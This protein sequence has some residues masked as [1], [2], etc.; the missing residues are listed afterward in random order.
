MIEKPGCKDARVRRQHGEYCDAD[1]HLT[2][3]LLLH[4]FAA[5]AI[6][7]QQNRGEFADGCI[8]AELKI[9]RQCPLI[10]DASAGY[11][12]RMDTT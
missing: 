7:G 3:L 12:C 6:A 5:P 4:R 1:K 2:Q 11:E 9:G 10:E 8:A